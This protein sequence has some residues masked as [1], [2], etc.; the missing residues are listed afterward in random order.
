MSQQPKKDRRQPRSLTSG[1]VHLRGMRA[2]LI[3]AVLA[4][5][6]IGGCDQFQNQ[7]QLRQEV[8][9]ADPQFAR[10]LEKRDQLADRVTLLQREF[11]V[12][13]GQIEQ[14]IT[15]LRD[16]LAQARRQ[17]DQKIRQ[18][19]SQLDADRQR[20]T[21]A[22]SMAQEEFKAKQQ[23]RASLGRSIS[24]LRKALK[25]PGSA[26]TSDDHTKMGLELAQ[27]LEE[28]A[29]L[30]QELQGLRSHLRLLKHKQALL[31]L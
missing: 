18:S 30:D 3:V 31:H 14:Q 21:L 23:Q 5:F 2:S 8:L 16:E 1:A 7:E 26:W 12:K 9:S 24:R 28:A 15:K 20:L 19:N 6:L 25:A 17:V 10:V 27:L 22:L 11:A 13:K 29:R 4:P